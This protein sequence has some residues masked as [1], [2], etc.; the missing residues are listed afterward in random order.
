MLM[1]EAT[2]YL[3]DNKQAGMEKDLEEDPEEDPAEDVAPDS[4]AEG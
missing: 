1:G 3:Q 2:S 4:P